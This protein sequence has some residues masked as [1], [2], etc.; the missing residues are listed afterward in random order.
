MTTFSCPLKITSE[1]VLYDHARDVI[2]RIAATL[3]DITFQAV[4]SRASR[5]SRVTFMGVDSW[6]L[7]QG[8]MVYQNR[9]ADSYVTVSNS[10]FRTTRSYTHAYWVYW[11][12]SD[13]GWRTLFRNNYDHCAIVEA[14][15]KR[16]GMA[17]SRVRLHE[18]TA[19]SMAS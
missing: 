7:G 4:P 10:G 1:D 15:L 14:G 8:S 5:P 3:G 12:Q 11:R 2:W 9:Y 17:L 18:L 6:Q 16:L 13:D 19:T